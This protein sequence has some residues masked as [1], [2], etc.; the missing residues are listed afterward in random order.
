MA[1]VKINSIASH[2]Y[3]VVEQITEAKQLEPSDS[4]KY[5]VWDQG[6]YAITLPKMSTNLAGWE[7]TLTRRSHASGATTITTHADD[8]ALVHYIEGEGDDSSSGTAITTITVVGNGTSSEVPCWVKLWTDGT[9]WYSLLFGI[10]AGTFT[11]A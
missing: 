4:G 8:G 7:I 10:A 6:S 2:N 11:Q 1:N 5:F 3:Q 9:S